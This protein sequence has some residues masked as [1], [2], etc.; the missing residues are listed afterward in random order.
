LL[1][2]ALTTIRLFLHVLAAAVWVGGQIVLAGLVPTV[3]SMG[4]G[5]TRT[6]ARSFARLSWPAYG[7]LLLT[8]I[9]NVS[10]VHPSHQT[11]PWKV[12]LGV[13]M[14]VVVLAGVAALL[15]TRA[16]S[17]RGLAI[18]GSVAGLSSVGALLLGV[19]LAG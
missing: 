2:P 12:V 18:W 7:V 17:R 10:A 11:T 5:A 8:G 16:S 15:H 4:E 3:R 6:V 19:L 1:A 14:G 9:W 13:K